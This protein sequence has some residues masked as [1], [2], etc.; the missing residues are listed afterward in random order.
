MVYPITPD[1]TIREVIKQLAEH[2]LGSLVVLNST[3]TPIG[4]ITERDVIRRA[5]DLSA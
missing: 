2:N 3:E 5:A 4:I 1:Q